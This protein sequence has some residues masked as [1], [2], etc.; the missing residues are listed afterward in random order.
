[1]SE[2]PPPP[3]ETNAGLVGGVIL[4]V[5]FTLIGFCIFLRLRQRRRAALRHTLDDEERRFQARLEAATSGVFSISGEDDELELTAH[6]IE[7]IQGLERELERKARGVPGAPPPEPT[8]SPSVAAGG[9]GNGGGGGGGGGSAAGG[10]GTGAGG[11]AAAAAPPTGEATT[12]AA[13]KRP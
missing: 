8:P 5:L 3:P 7:A 6:E 12:S 11:G 13:E 10:A 2:S 4:G 1:M 9:G